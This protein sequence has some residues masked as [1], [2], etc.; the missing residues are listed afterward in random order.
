MIAFFN[1]T[2]IKA[3]TTAPYNP[4]MN[5]KAKRLIRTIMS[6]CGRCFWSTSWRGRCERSC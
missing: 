1:E 6:A 3:K 5:G 4:Q 2:G